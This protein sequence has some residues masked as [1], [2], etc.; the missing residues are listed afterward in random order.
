VK[1]SNDTIGNRTRDLPVCSAVPQLTAPPRAP[2]CVKAQAITRRPLTAEAL[3][4]SQISSCDIC[5]GQNGTGTRLSPSTSV[6]PCQ[7]QS[8]NAP[9]SSSSTCCCYHKR[10]RSK[11][12]NLKKNFF[13]KSEELRKKKFF[14]F[15]MF[16]QVTR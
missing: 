8:T 9:Y 4:R 15:S 7:Y 14:Y 12:G 1:N 5:C 10:K 11:P 16:T 6:S 2:L 3:V 13:R